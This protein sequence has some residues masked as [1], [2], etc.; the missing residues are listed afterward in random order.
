MIVTVCANL[1]ERSFNNTKNFGTEFA[2]MDVDGI[3]IKDVQTM[4]DCK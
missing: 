1:H 4:S 3:R 2:I